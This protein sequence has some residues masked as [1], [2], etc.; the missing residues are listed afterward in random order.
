MEQPIVNGAAGFPFRVMPPRSSSHL[1]VVPLQLQSVTESM[2]AKL[3]RLRPSPPE[4][5]STA[6]AA[7]AGGLDGTPAQCKSATIN[8]MPY[9][10]TRSDAPVI[11]NVR[12]GSASE[13][14]SSF[15]LEG[16]P[17]LVDELSG[18]ATRTPVKLR[19]PRW[20]APGIGFI[21]RHPLLLQQLPRSSPLPCAASL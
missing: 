13:A 1:K 8:K 18:T 5:K 17:A 6:P 7:E 3:K 9:A 14:I 19:Q 11:R 10:I 15:R 16:E 4:E 2:E 21:T 20:S 12:R